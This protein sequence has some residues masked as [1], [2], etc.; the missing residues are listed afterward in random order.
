MISVYHV[1]RVTTLEVEN[2]LPN[3][4]LLNVSFALKTEIVHTY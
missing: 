1:D 4:D 2:I 3:T